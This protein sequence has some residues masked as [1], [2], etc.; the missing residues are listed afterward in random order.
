MSSNTIRQRAKRRPSKVGF[1]QGVGQV[2]RKSLL[3]MM[4]LS[5]ATVAGSLVGLA[6]SFRNLPDVRLLRNYVPNQTTHIYD[7]KGVPIASFHGEANR[8]VVPLEAISPNL[9]RALLAIEDSY[10]YYHSGVNPG[11]IARAFLVNFAQGETREGG[12]TLTMQLVKN[13]FLSPKRTLSRKIAEAVLALRIEQVFPKDKILEMYL[14]QVYWGHNNYGIQTA[15]ESYF[16]KSAENLT[17]GESAMLAGLV[18]A[19][20]VFSPF[21]NP[22]IAKQRQ[23]IVLNRMLEL[24]WI[25]EKDKA[26][27]LKQKLK[28]GKITAFEASKAPYVTDAL[29]QELAQKLGKDL[30]ARGGLR[31]QA[32]VDFK[33]QQIAEQAVKDNFPYVSYFADQMAIVSVDPRTHFIKAIVGGVDYKKSQYNRATQAFRQPGSSF[34]PFVYYTAFASGKYS[35]DSTIN[36]APVSYREGSEFYEP[37]NYDNTFAGPMS[38]RSALAMSRNIPAITIGQS[39]G[40]DK[41]IQ[42]CKTLGITS[43]IIPVISLPLGSIEVTP[44]EMASAYAT[45]AN[46]G[47]QSPTTIIAQVTDSAGNTLIDNT[48][49]PKLVLDP[50]AAASLNSALQSVI[51]G[52]TGS[53]AAIGRPAGGKTGTTSSERDIWFVGFVPQLSTAVWVGNDDNSPL[54]RGVTGGVVVGPIWGDYMS[55]VLKDS[56]VEY[57]VP[58]SEFPAP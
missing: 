22:K 8:E 11:G 57:F 48:P 46:N 15:A 40:L 2:T 12:S 10:F 38:L 37:Q 1:L 44:L 33:M 58:A 52:G 30:I 36:D 17:L 18:Q 56:P 53:H 27:A 45:F 21:I 29:T 32:T 25:T 35:P 20:E 47:W 55:R 42:V 7:I 13:V 14:N 49:K 24:N 19:P 28:F 3:A 23:A 34:K 26:D 31:V 16:N 5:S 4:L 51:N 9:K 43:P 54:G 41:V 6:I 39:V 50:W